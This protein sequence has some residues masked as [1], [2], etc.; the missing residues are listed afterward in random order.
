MRLAIDYGTVATRAVLAWP[1]GRWSTLMFDGADQLPSGVYVDADA[2]VWV[3]RPA[4][5]RAVA[6]PAGFV[7]YPKRHL[8]QTHIQVHGRGIEVVDLIAAVLRRVGEEA[9]RV[10]GQ[11]ADEV[12]LTTSPRWP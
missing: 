3:G 12:T 9:T 1:D 11:P 6:D 5:D 7:P 8:P 2:T 10:A 4:R